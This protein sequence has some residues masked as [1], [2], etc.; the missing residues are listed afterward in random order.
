[1]DSKKAEEIWKK[2]S[3]NIKSNKTKIKS[4]D[5]SPIEMIVDTTK[6]HYERNAK[7][8]LTAGHKKFVG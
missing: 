2:F 3:S 1:M 8:Y 7:R 6:D 4:L 5:I